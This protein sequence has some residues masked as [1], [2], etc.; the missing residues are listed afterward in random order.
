MKNEMEMHA[1][2]LCRRCNQKFEAHSCAGNPLA[3]TGACPSA[4]AFPSWPRSV[5]DEAKAGAIY[6][7]RVKAFWAASPGVFLPK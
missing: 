1:K 4:P 5:R 6:D 2:H 7:K 3:A